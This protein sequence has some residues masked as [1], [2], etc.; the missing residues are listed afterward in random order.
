MKNYVAPEM[1]VVIVDVE[2]VIASSVGDH[3]YDAAN[4]DW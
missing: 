3:E 4:F 1:D 2:N